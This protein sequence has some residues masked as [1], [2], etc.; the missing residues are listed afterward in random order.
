MKRRIDECDDMVARIA[1]TIV[2]YV[3]LCGSLR[4]GC[5][6][7]RSDVLDRYCMSH[8]PSCR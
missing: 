3:V 4:D 5:L 8:V 2:T 1:D 6:W 7:H